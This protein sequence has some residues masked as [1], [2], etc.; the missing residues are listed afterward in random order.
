[1]N[2][3]NTSAGAVFLT[4]G[5]LGTGLGYLWAS[6]PSEPTP[7]PTTVATPTTPND[8]ATIAAPTEPAN[9]RR[10]RRQRTDNGEFDLSNIPSHDWVSIYDP[11]KAWPGYTLL[12]YDR[13]VPMIVDMNGNVV[14]SWAEIRAVGRARLTP[15]GSLLYIDVDDTLKEVGWN[16][17]EI[18]TFSTGDSKYFPH[19]DL[20][21]A[22]D[23]EILAIFRAPGE[24]TD[25]V[26]A[27][28]ASGA[29]AWTWESRNH[30]GADL[31]K[32]AYKDNDLTHFNSVQAIPDNPHARAGDKRFQA[33]NILISSRHLSTIYLV[34]RNTGGVT[35]KY[36]D[37]LDWQHEAVL[38]DDDVPGAGNVLFFNNRYHSED[39]R[40]EVVEI[41]PIKNEVVWRYTSDRFFSDTAGT[42]QKLPNGNVVITSSR[43]GRIF[44]VTPG[45]E[46][47]WQWTPPH[48]P[49]RSQ[50]Y[51]ADFCPQLAELPPMQPIPV[52]DSQPKPFVDEALYRFVLDKE[53][54]KAKVDGKKR[55]LLPKSNDCN[56]LKLPGKPALV[57][58]YGFMLAEELDPAQAKGEVTVTL[59]R[60]G[61]APQAVYEKTVTLAESGPWVRDRL[62]LDPSWGY[63]DVEMCIQ[64]N[65][66]AVSK[67]DRYSPGFVLAIP[68]ISTAYK[69]PRRDLPRVTANRKRDKP[70]E[71]TL[72]Q[73][74]LEALG[75]IE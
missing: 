59:A 31:L 36:T 20:Q 8:P 39:R 28:D 5:T 35:W 15:S 75:Y 18:R 68:R 34:D 48:N 65:A 16:G 13:R 53:I 61:E 26:L 62:K 58:E 69:P 6:P 32:E 10:Q 60:A 56:Q 47:V 1:M 50:R 51:A 46:I 17:E 14:H 22:P 4:V 57:M 7:A 73:R 24:P 67:A 71:R 33:G 72:Q 27:I 2:W 66:M 74:Q 11:G 44:E 30:L 41:D 64:S 54:V 38:L 25:N 52:T 9:E 21:W 37:E 45:G 55:V 29:L 3:T 43:G 19:H 63:S 23:N 49:M 70:Y 42:A 12:F 40:S